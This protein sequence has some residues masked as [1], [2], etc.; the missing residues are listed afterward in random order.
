V[1]KCPSTLDPEWLSELS[2][3]KSVKPNAA[4]EHP[5][6]HSLGKITPIL[7]YVNIKKNRKKGYSL[8]C[9]VNIHVARDLPQ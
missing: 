2:T 7:V 1:L 9:N 5:K 4:A 8:P 6:D 3:N